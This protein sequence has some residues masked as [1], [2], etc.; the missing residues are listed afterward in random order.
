MQHIPASLDLILD[1][2]DR[3]G[4]SVVP[5]F[6][7]VATVVQLA[8]ET[9]QLN[10]AHALTPAG[11]GKGAGRAVNGNIRG[12][13]ILWLEEPDLSKAQHDYLEALEELRLVANAG[14]QLGLF[15]FEGHLAVYPLGS[16]YRKHLDR[17]Q[18]D[19]LRTLTV[20]LY[21]NEN[22]CVEEGGQLRVYTDENICI[23]ML[24]HSGASFDVLPQGG[25]L[26]AFL[27]DRF[28]HE[29]LPASR[30]RL[31]ITGWFKTRGAAML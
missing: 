14:L 20:I 11:V 23:N 17:F 27:S 31:S 19:S 6:M 8:H 29:V 30:E 18:N 2:L 4:W 12:D 9:L 5:G 13:A 22:W 25:T 16:F 24:P 7:P 3:Q 1:D 28:W 26:V 21:L 10:R 15:E